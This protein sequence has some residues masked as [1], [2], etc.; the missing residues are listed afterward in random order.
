MEEKT[1]EPSG[2]YVGYVTP[3]EPVHPVKP[4]MKKAE[5]VHHLIQQQH[6]LTESCMTLDEDSTVINTGGKEVQ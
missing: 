3:E 4:A 6:D 1:A 2:S 5:A